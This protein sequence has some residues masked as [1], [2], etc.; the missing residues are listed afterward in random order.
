MA[1]D[2]TRQLIQQITNASNVGENTATR[3]G[4]AMEAMLND[5][6]A[7]D[8]KAVAA[9]NRINTTEQGI[10]NANQRLSTE[11]GINA[12]QTAQIAGLKQDLQNIRPVTIEGDVVNNPDNVFLTSANDEITPKERTTS[13]S[14]KGHYIM[15]PTD[16]FAAKLKANYIHEIPFDVDLGGASVAIPANAV[17]KFT[18]GKIENGSLVL[19]NTYLDGD[20][21]LGA[22]VAVSGTCANP[23]A[24]Q[25]WFGNNVDAWH[26][27]INNVDCQVYEYTEGTYNP[28]TIVSVGNR[29]RFVIK[30]NNAKLIW[31]GPTQDA[32]AQYL[33]GGINVNLRNFSN[34]TQIT[35]A[36]P[37]AYNSSEI[38]VS[39]DHNLSVGDVIVLH[40]SRDSSFTKNFQNGEYLNVRAVNGNTIGLASRTFAQYP[41]IANISAVKVEQTFVSIEDL[42]LQYLVDNEDD[43]RLWIGA[44]LCHTYG[45]ITNVKINGFSTSL[46]LL[47][48]YNVDVESCELFPLQRISIDRTR[49]KYGLMVANCQSVHVSKCHIGGGQHALST[50]GYGGNDV[51]YTPNRSIYIHNNTIANEQLVNWASIGFHENIEYA[52]ITDNTVGGI[53]VTGNMTV[54]ENN[55]IRKNGSGSAYLLS[56]ILTFNHIFSNN[57]I[58]DGGCRIETDRIDRT[59]YPNIYDDDAPENLLISNNGGKM[60]FSLITSKGNASKKIQATINGNNLVTSASSTENRLKCDFDKVVI[61]NC[62]FEQVGTNANCP[63]FIGSVNDVEISDSIFSTPTTSGRCIVMGGNEGYFGSNFE[64]GK[65]K[66]EGCTFKS[67]SNPGTVDAYSSIVL[68]NNTGKSNVARLEVLANKFGKAVNGTIKALYL[69]NG[70]TFDTVIIDK[71]IFD[72]EALGNYYLGRCKT[73][74]LGK[75]IYLKDYHTGG[76]HHSI[77][78]DIIEGIQESSLST[79][80]YGTTAERPS[81]AYKGMGSE[82]YDTDIKRKIYSDFSSVQKHFGSYG[83]ASNNLTEGRKYRIHA[84][85]RDA[86]VRVY[87]SK[88]NANPTDDDLMLVYEANVLLGMFVDKEIIAPNPTTYPYIYKTSTSSSYTSFYIYEDTQ[89]WREADG[90]SAGVARSGE[91]ANR[92]TGGNV[93]VGFRFFDTTL[94]KPIFA[95]AISGNTVTWVDATGT[96]V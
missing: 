60:R 90:A 21:K 91:T 58:E 70:N 33:S 54:V 7:A 38:V 79:R 31:N 84:G 46:E 53:S 55:I 78:A 51:F 49:A 8:D 92:P 32:P 25:S 63:L 2:T 16:N 83:F 36:E 20:V 6:K 48:S 82:Y 74:M 72:A 88:V 35:I 19:Q 64:V 14:A 50:G 56:S 47:T 26:R 10:A 5:V 76:L 71:N 18:G 28:N 52:Y 96:T 73:A 22:D 77:V 43:I 66:I 11:E 86:K 95:K 89:T 44:I 85:N 30:G 34:Y 80:N 62:L 39:D 59:D 67:E 15:R 29:R 24:Y 45:R 3:V 9:T 17:L 4:N 75:N 57:L 69:G 41:N 27:F 37:I 94:G 93:Y 81:I 61:K 65:I 1:I 13:L 87:F 42:T 12:V 68:Y 23:T 40:D